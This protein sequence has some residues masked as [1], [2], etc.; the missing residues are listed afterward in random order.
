MVRACCA[1]AG[2]VAVLSFAVLIFAA[3]GCCARLAGALRRAHHVNLTTI[4]GALLGNVAADAETALTLAEEVRGRLPQT[5]DDNDFVQLCA[6]LAFSIVTIRREA[7][8]KA[9]EAGQPVA[10]WLDLNQPGW[11]KVPI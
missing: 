5:F 7:E 4:V 2:V 11:Q 8:P 1:Q 3:F 10:I 6:D 9:A